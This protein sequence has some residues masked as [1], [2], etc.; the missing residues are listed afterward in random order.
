M[1]ECLSF[2]TPLISLL[3]FYHAAQFLPPF[4]IWK[5]WLVQ[6]TIQILR[7]AQCKFIFSID[8]ETRIFPETDNEQVPWG[9]DEKNFEKRAKQYNLIITPM[10]TCRWYGSSLC[11]CNGWHCRNN[12]LHTATPPNGTEQYSSPFA[13]M[14]IVPAGCDAQGIYSSS[15]L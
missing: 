1:I 4:R 8:N 3:P 2:P 7:S 9:K 13:A 5:R 10:H 12:L 11:H 14:Y 6:K 15:V